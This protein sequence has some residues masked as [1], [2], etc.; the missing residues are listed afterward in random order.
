MVITPSVPA[1]PVKLCKRDGCNKEIFKNRIYCSAIC[2]NQAMTGISPTP[3]GPPIEYKPEFCTTKLEE[4][5][6]MVIEANEEKLI[7]GANGGWTVLNR[8][9]VPTKED[10]AHFLGFNGRTIYKWEGLYPDFAHAMD[11]LLERQ[12]QMLF[13]Y[14]MAGRYN[15]GLARVV[16]SQHGVIEKRDPVE[17]NI[18]LLGMVKHVYEEADRLTAEELEKHKQLTDGTTGT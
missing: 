17:G 12:K 16:L 8:S 6:E 13:D 14:G 7:K 18:T 1:T 11:Y 2:K 9:K 15:A 3:D 5:F 4:Y 10:Y